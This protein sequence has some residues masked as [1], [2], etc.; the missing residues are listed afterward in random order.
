MT[1][2]SKISA[3]L[4]ATCLAA[5]CGKSEA[6]PVPAKVE[7]PKEA[8]APAAKSH[9]SLVMPDACALLDAGEVATAAGWKS[10]NAVKVNT[11]AEYLATCDYVDAANPSRLV[12]VAIAFG[13]LIPDDSANYAEIV[14]DREGTLKQPATPVTTFGIPTIEMDGGPGAQSMQ[15]RFE[16]TTELTVT[17][18]TQQITRVLFPRA[19]IKLRALPEL[20]SRN[21]S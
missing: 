5:G 3:I 12:K 4:I 17:T 13:A 6:P 18:P 16:P 21:V 1:C 10:A 20:Q 9:T 15:T 14:G 2:T 19:L 8:A 11:G 7:P